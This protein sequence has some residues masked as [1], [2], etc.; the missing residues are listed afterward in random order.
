MLLNS[1]VTLDQSLTSPF[2]KMGEQVF[3]LSAE[4]YMGGGGGRGKGGNCSPGKKRFH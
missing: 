3:I 4:P 1:R 2:Q